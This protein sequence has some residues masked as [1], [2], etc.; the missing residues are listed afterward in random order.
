M[1]LVLEAKSK[2]QQTS[3][4]N[5]DITVKLCGFESVI[6]S[7]PGPINLT[8]EANTGNQIGFNVKD[9]LMSSKKVCPLVKYEMLTLKND[10]KTLEA[11]AG[12]QL[13]LDSSQYLFVKTGTKP[14]SQ[15]L[16]VRAHTTKNKIN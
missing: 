13:I 2:G 3:R 1:K 9:K 15:K 10:G 14:F 12:T 5:M 6:L 4:L 16:I 11:Y 7:E 8:F